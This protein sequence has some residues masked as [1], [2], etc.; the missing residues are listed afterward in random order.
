MCVCVC[1]AVA[2]ETLQAS[3]P[4]PWYMVLRSPFFSLTMELV[5]V[6]VFHAVVLAVT[7]DGANSS[8]SRV[9]FLVI[10]I[11]N[12]VG[13]G[14]VIMACCLASIRTLGVH[15]YAPLLREL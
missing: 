9:I 13:P 6:I 10:E 1:E 8:W 2:P 7:F 3:P 4:K 15:L 12:L 14:P 5:R 11:S